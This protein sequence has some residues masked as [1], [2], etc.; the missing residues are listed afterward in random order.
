[1]EPVNIKK[2]SETSI[3]KEKP[4]EN[5]IIGWKRRKLSGTRIKRKIEKNKWN[6]KNQKRET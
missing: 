5:N 3:Q 1:M 4:K 6:P 2:A